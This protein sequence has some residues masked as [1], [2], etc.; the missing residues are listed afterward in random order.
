MFTAR[1]K[2][3][4]QYLLAMVVVASTWHPSKAAAAAA[5]AVGRNAQTS[6]G[7]G[8]VDRPTASEAQQEALRR[9]SIRGPASCSVVTTFSRTCLAIAVQIGRNGYGWATRP[10]IGEARNTVLSQCLAHGVPCDVKV[11]LCDSGESRGAPPTAS[12][13][14]APAPV[15]PVRTSEPQSP[16]RACERYPELCQ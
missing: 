9:C 6:W 15:P 8:V 7:S 4:R 2:G 1:P 14:P 16:Q 12:P 5:F 13:M 10:T 3:G 11:A